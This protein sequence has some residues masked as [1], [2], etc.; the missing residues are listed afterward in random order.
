MLLKV[1][2]V[3]EKHISDTD[4]H[5]FPEFLHYEVIVVQT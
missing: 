2:V 5:S 3:Y 1:F 4:F